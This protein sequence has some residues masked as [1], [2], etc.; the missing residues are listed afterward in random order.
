MLVILGEPVSPFGVYRNPQGKLAFN[1]DHMQQKDTR[2]SLFDSSQK[3]LADIKH[4][5]DGGGNDSSIEAPKA[6]RLRI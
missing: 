3:V 2:S 4:G 6:K 1:F 5:A